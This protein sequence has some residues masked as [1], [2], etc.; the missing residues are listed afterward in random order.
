MTPVLHPIED[1]SDQIDACLH[2]REIGL[3]TIGYHIVH[4]YSL[5]HYIID[6]NAI[7]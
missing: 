4:V 2:R 7:R 5:A 6:L 1:G 3:L